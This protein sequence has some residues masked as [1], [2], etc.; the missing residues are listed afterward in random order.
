MT[1][2]ELYIDEE[3]EFYAKSYQKGYDDGLANAENKAYENGFKDGIQ[4]Q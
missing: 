2:N 3:K 4:V 1:E